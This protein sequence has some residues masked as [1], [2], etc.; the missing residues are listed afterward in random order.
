MNKLH[1]EVGSLYQSTTQARMCRAGDDLAL[2]PNLSLDDCKNVCLEQKFVESSYS[3]GK[4]VLVFNVFKSSL[5]IL[6]R[7]ECEASGR[8]VEKVSCDSFQYTA[9]G[10]GARGLCNLK[11]G[12][13][14]AVEVCA[15][16]RTESYDF[17]CTD[18]AEQVSR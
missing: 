9:D 2:I 5:D 14:G 7:E 15:D 18:G 13:S 8:I 3:D 12:R 6:T 11:Y 10:D 4:C 17:T 16:Q 1:A